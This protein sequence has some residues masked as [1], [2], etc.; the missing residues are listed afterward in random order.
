MN[1][2]SYIKSFKIECNIRLRKNEDEEKIIKQKIDV[3][4]KELGAAESIFNK[5][6][7]TGLTIGLAGGGMIGTIAAVIFN[8]AIW[9]IYLIATILLTVLGLLNEAVEKNKEEDRFYLNQEMRSLQREHSKIKRE[10]EHILNLIENLGESID[11]YLNVLSI[12]QR[13]LPVNIRFQRIFDSNNK[14]STLLHKYYNG[15]LQSFMEL[16]EHERR[17]IEQQL[18]IKGIIYKSKKENQE[19]NKPKRRRRYR[20]EQF[21]ETNYEQPSYTYARAR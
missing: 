20:E 4:E 6:L 11:Y 16:P 19:E 1:F 8:A 9:P 12:E 21:Y 5:T 14:L 18:D 10:K 7:P 3:L 2:N 17:L 13:A 15:E